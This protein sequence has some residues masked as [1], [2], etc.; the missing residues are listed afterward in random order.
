[1]KDAASELK[2]TTGFATYSGVPRRC[3]T[4]VLLR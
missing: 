3:I 1:M 4:A 2:K